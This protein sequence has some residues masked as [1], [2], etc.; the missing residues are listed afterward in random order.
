MMDKV[1]NPSTVKPQFIIFTGGPEKEQWEWENDRW[2]YKIGFVQGPQT[3]ND[4]SERTIQPGMI[5]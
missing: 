5:D 2:G 3:L 4:G 1:H